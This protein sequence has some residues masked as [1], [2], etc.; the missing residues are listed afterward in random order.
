MSRSYAHRMFVLLWLASLVLWWHALAATFGLA[1]QNDAYTHILLI[2]AICIALI[3]SE[4]RSRRAQPEPN[5][6]A[7]LALLALVVL[8]RFIG[9]G[10]LGSVVLPPEV[11]VSLGMLAGVS[12]WI[13]AFVCCFGT[14]VFRLFAFSL[15]FLL[16]LVLLP[17]FSVNHIVS[18][19][20]QGSADAANRLFIIAGI[21]VTRDGLRVS[22]PGL[23]VEVATECSSIRSSLM[24]LVTS[25]V[26]A[27]LLLRSAWG[28]GLVIV[29][30]I[31]LYDC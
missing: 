7:G 13:G 16:W 4:W 12:W 20:Q 21:P 8:I 1:L 2:L 10:W 28:K 6:R 29:A 27:H 25:T 30:A 18:L 19:L 15:C 14:R 3:V 11:Q 5:V 17:E 24:L 23:T 31:P 9:H 26:P 22:V